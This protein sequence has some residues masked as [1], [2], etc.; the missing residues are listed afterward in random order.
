MVRKVLTKVKQKQTNPKKREEDL[1]M[2][3]VKFK[4]SSQGTCRQ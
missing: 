1:Q 4:F 2:A 3:L